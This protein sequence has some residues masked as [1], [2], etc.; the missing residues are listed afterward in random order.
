MAEN[1]ILSPVFERAVPIVFGADE[2]F[3]IPLV[4]CVQSIV[5]NASPDEC[6]DIVVLANKFGESYVSMLCSIAE[7][8]KNVSI[9]V[10]DVEPFLKSFD[11]SRLKTG[12]RL[13]LAAYYRLFI[14]ELMKDYSKA[15]Y[16]DGD[17][18]LLE[19]IAVLY[20]A[21]VS[22]Y[23]A[24]VVKDYNIIRDMSMSFRRHVQQVLQME[25]IGAYFNSGVLVLNLD[26]IRRDFSLPFFM[27]QAELKGTKHHDQDVLNSLFYGR[28][29]YL[30]PRFNSM[31]QDRR[32]YASVEGGD[33]AVHRPAI[34]HYP[35]GGKPWLK[36]GAFREAS[37]HFWK[38]A[39]KCPYA[40]EI[41]EA[42]RL[43][44][45][46]S[47]AGYAEQKKR[48]LW[49]KLL[50]LLLFGRKRR[51]YAKKVQAMLRSLAETEA[52]MKGGEDVFPW[53]AVQKA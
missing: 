53:K 15:L 14:P 13:S 30:S 19:D 49:Y 9:R 34:V 25:D 4:V 38:Y 32:L 8:R 40:E 3:F 42:C 39:V 11:M 27:E 29:R 31:W 22:G 44:C 21:D 48:Y 23:Y 20:H 12:H 35:G 26:M 28:V 17:T 46:R 43:D 6:Y 50:S 7:G 33:E 36:G 10:H 47:V 1:S 41:M 52:L 2:G 5:D 16:I 24:A 51:H 45:A 18:V 37:R